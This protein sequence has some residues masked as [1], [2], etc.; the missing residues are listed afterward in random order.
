MDEDHLTALE[1]ALIKEQTKERKAEI[2]KMLRRNDHTVL[3]A[4]GKVFGWLAGA[5][6]LF[7]GTMAGVNYSVN[8]RVYTRYDRTHVESRVDGWFSHTRLEDGNEDGMTVWQCSPLEN[9]TSRAYTDVDRD[10]H[11]DHVWIGLRSNPLHG[12]DGRLYVRGEPFLNFDRVD[13]TFNRELERFGYRRDGSR[14]R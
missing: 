4:T 7:F 6:A 14:L 13:R 2:K 8:E 11:V 9:V 1:C 12:V 3:K 5:A 10:G